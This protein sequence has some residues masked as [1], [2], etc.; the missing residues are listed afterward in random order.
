MKE[1]LWRWDKI[2]DGLKERKRKNSSRAE[3]GKKEGRKEEWG[4][5]EGSAFL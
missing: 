3:D 1:K 4:R 5:K 2:K